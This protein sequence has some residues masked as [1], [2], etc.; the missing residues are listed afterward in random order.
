MLLLCVSVSLSCVSP[1]DILSQSVRTAEK[2]VSTL[3]LS[4]FTSVTEVSEFRIGFIKKKKRKKENQEILGFYFWAV[5]L[6]DFFFTS[7]LNNMSN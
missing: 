6:A 5:N 7:V 1:P 2:L 3:K 4:G